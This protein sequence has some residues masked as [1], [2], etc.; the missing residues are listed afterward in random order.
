MPK[1][2]RLTI[3]LLAL[4][5]LPLFSAGV[6]AQGIPPNILNFTIE[7]HIPGEPLRIRA[8][9]VD[10]GEIDQCRLYFRCPGAKEFDYVPFYT[11]YDFFIAE[12]PPEFLKYGSIEYYLYT[13][14]TEGNSTTSPEINPEENAYELFVRPSF[15]R[16]AA[17]GNP[18]DIALLS[19]E[20]GST[21]PVS[22]E[23]VVVSLYDPEDDMMPLSVK[24]LVDGRDVT[25]RAQVTKDL[26]TY[27]P[28][29][30]FSVGDHT[31]EVSVIDQEGNVATRKF[32]FAVHRVDLRREPSEIAGVKWSFS[33]SLESKYDKYEGREQPSNRP[34][35]YNRPRFR[36]ALDWGWLKTEGEVFYNYYFDDT[37][38]ELDERRQSMNRYR[39]KFITKPLE[40]TLGDANPRFSELTIKGTRLRGVSGEF[41]Y[42]FLG[43]QGCFGEITQRIDP[44][45]LDPTWTNIIKDTTEYDS[46]YS[47]VVDSAYFYSSSAP[48]YRRKASGIRTTFN[49]THDIKF[50]LNYLRFKDDISDSARFDEEY[51]QIVEYEYGQYDSLEFINNYLIPVKGILDPLSPEAEPYWEVWRLQRDNQVEG[52]GLAGM[53]GKPKDNI[54]MSSTLDMRIFRKTF[55]SVEA[56]LSLLIEDQ[57]GNRDDIDK[58]HADLENDSVEVSDDDKLIA[59]VDDLMQDYFDFELNNS[60][61]F[62]L[63]TPENGYI[64]PVLYADLRTPL[65]L[66]PTS[67]KLTY[68]RIPESYTSL[69]NPSLQKDIDAIK[70]DTRTRMLKNRVTLSLGGEYK[71]DNL[72]NAKS[73]TTDNTT[74][75]TGIGLVFPKFPT[76]NVGFRQIHREGVGLTDST[77]IDSLTTIGVFDTSKVSYD[78]TFSSSNT[79]TITVSAG[80][81]LQKGGFSANLSANLMLMNYSNDK[82]SDLDFDNNSYILSTNISFP[83]PVGLD[84]SYGESINSPETS[85]E[86]AYTILNSR[87]SYYLLNRK[88]TLFAG[89]NILDGSKTND[90]DMDNGI[91]N[92]KRTIRGGIKWKIASRSSIYLD[93]EYIDFKDNFGPDYREN[94]AKMK[95]DFQ[96]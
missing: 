30:D 85:N 89:Y 26:I 9:I 69:G 13:V 18:T 87:L 62:T 65:P 16:R 91:D 6:F 61:Q 23:L 14:D 5:I 72:Y 36:A 39:L 47:I 64:K 32:D 48:I 15:T 33:G 43:L 37:A 93:Y 29:R 49:L 52:V 12:V 4:T 17:E 66:L 41:K 45:K 82:N 51:T 75:S 70:A 57:F 1:T 22:P 78:S 38:R 35:D 80:Y 11:E 55:I 40:L 95:L 84:V 58:I 79:S 77:I 86:I 60:F 68:R 83:Y 74:I 73:L 46:T 10:D 63:N 54:V 31:I 56:A 24:L 50:G 3:S 34:I 53:M 96:L 67:L 28:S 19:P 2:G 44:Y 25:T 21:I 7:E 20:P 42:G 88:I 71:S 90:P 92:K 8:I 81:R 27:L 76:L 94:R 59:D